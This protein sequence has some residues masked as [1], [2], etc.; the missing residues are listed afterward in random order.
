V[1]MRRW[2]L[3]LAAFI[4]SVAI[5]YGISFTALGSKAL[6]IG[7][8]IDTLVLIMGLL[9]TATILL[10]NLSHMRALRSTSTALALSQAQTL[11]E[12]QRFYRRLDHELKN[13]LTAIRAGLANLETG[14]IDGQWTEARSS[15]E[16][17]IMRL[18]RLTSNLRKLV[19]IESRPLYDQGSIDLGDLLTEVF[20]AGE[21]NPLAQDR[22][23]S[24]SLPQAPWP[25]PE[26]SGDRDLLFLAFFNL[27]DNALKFTQ[28]E[29]TIELRAFEDRPNIVVEIADTGIGIADE[30]TPL[31][32]E[33]LY[34]GQKAHGIPGS[35]LGLSLVRA[36][37]AR[38]GGNTEIRSKEK[39]G[40]VITIRI[41]VN[42][43]VSDL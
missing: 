29:D 42:S 36:I 43:S 19:D 31:V 37:I 1:K 39:H 13:P 20:E 23:M 10:S 21:E 5:S 3:P 18:S 14:N 7:I 27:I 30:E 33:D 40:T 4:L 9:V 25:L 11:K 12:R 41:P 26:I 6:R 34:R 38:H 24:L 17:Q 8:E 28:L 22:T 15:I 32:W 16:S 2:P 35:G